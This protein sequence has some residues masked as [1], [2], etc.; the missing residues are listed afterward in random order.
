M[1]LILLLIALLVAPAAAAHGNPASDSP[2]AAAAAEQTDWGVA[3][4]TPTRTVTV[5]ML[6][7]MRFSPDRLAVAAGETIRFVI[8]N[9]GR[10]QHEMVIGTPAMLAEHAALMAKHPGMEHDAAHM[11]HVA[12]GQ[13][14]EIV[15]TFNRTG[16]FEYACL[17]PGH[18]EAGM[19]GR[20][21]VSAVA[22]AQAPAAAEPP[23]QGAER[24]GDHS[25][26]ALTLHRGR[27][28]DPMPT[29]FRAETP[30]LSQR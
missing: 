15:W 13:R 12:P 8:R 1:K 5:D 7:S 28:A 30:A 17:L 24:T 26:G 6:D 18:L 27:S 2:G 23:G 25:N 10:M 14:G 29:G 11:A 20:I 3:G 22:P 16:E 9:R 21:V 4:G 19:R